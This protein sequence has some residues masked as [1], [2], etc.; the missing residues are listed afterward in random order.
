MSLLARELLFRLDDELRASFIER[1]PDV[2]DLLQEQDRL[3]GER[4]VG[5]K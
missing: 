5:R 1:H 2:L 4:L 3:L